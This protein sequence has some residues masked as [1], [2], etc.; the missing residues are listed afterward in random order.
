MQWF[1]NL[2]LQSVC[3]LC[4]RSTAQPLCRAC[5]QQIRSCRLNTPWSPVTPPLFAW[6]NYTGSL[7]RAITT[8][9]YQN[10]PELSQ[11]LGWLVG[12]AWHKNPLLQTRP[13][14]VPIP[15]HKEKLQQRG[16]NQAELL[17][18][19]FSQAAGLSLQP[20]ILIR[21]R[22]TQA[23]YAVAGQDRERNLAGAFQ[24]RHHPRRPVL[25]FDDIYTTGATVRSAIATLNQAGITVAAIVVLART[26]KPDYSPSISG[27]MGS[28]S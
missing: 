7:R 6:G 21:Q 25:L 10:H 19:S 26:E 8:L 27:M 11:P 15:M 14:V 20:N 9:K 16:F 5:D 4:Q 24:V 22:A 28:L 13:V 12:Q 2:F 1:F 23:Q 3:P 17:A 18:R